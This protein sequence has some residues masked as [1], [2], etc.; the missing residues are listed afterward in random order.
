MDDLE[1]KFQI[2]S[3]RLGVAEEL[4]HLVGVFAGFSAN[5]YF[6]SFWFYIFGYLAS[7][8]AVPYFYSKEY[9][10]ALRQL[11]ESR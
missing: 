10:R 9:D 11:S 4:R 6:E 3:A 5:L 7:L 1:I 2:A 8:F